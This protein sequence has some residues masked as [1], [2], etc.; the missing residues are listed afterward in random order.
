MMPA[1]VSSQG[2]AVVLVLALA[3]IVVLGMGRADRVVPRGSR[4]ESW[5]HRWTPTAQGLV[6]LGAIVWAIHIAFGDDASMWRWLTMGV[7]A[8]AAWS[9][10]R[11]LSDWASGVFLRSEGTLRP[12]ARIGVGVERGRIRHLGL[13]SVEVEVEDGRV[14]RLPYTSL[15]EAAVEV[16]PEEIAARSHTFTVDVPADSDT[17][18]ISSRL[19]AAALLSPWSSSQ[20]GPSV[21]LLGESEGALRFEVTVYPVDPAFV[22]K[23]ESAVR[24]DT[25]AQSP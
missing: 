20:P 7:F 6:V 16:S 24:A 2:V 12:G 5:V 9:S 11:S 15:A 14:L 23:V 1:F 21:R 25:S 3:V 18:E 10:R 17:G 8:A 13:R 22:S 4:L 19:A